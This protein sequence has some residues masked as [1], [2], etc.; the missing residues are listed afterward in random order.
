MVDE[1]GHQARAEPQ[2]GPQRKKQQSEKAAHRLTGG[3]GDEVVGYAHF[4]IPPGQ[5]VAAPD[6]LLGGCSTRSASSE[7]F[8]KPSG[9]H[10]FLTSAARAS[11]TE[12]L[13]EKALAE[14]ADPAQRHPGLRHR[15][16]E[17]LCRGPRIVEHRIGG[18]TAPPRAPGKTRTFLPPPFRA[19]DS[20]RCPRRERDR[21]SIRRRGRS[22]ADIQRRRNRIPGRVR[23]SRKIRVRGG[24]SRRS[25][26]GRGPR[27]ITPPSRSR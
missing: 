6:V 18:G 17:P 26:G 9:Q 10:E 12:F 14:P 23:G 2:P 8:S 3:I 21:N 16:A 15:P 13:I 7:R 25:S 4:P 5:P 11:D 19:A 27:E 1:E 20:A 24:E 22:R